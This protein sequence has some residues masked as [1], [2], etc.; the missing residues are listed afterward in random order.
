MANQQIARDPNTPVPQGLDEDEQQAA[1]LKAAK[2]RGGV[3]RG[4]QL[5]VVPLGTPPLPS[6]WRAA[7]KV[8]APGSGK[9]YTVYMIIPPKRGPGPTGTPTNQPVSDAGTMPVT[10]NQPNTQT[11]IIPAESPQAP[12]NQLAETW[13]G[14]GDSDALVEYTEE[15]QKV[16][17]NPNATEDQI[18]EKVKAGLAEARRVSLLGGGDRDNSM[19]SALMQQ[20]GKAV[21]QVAKMKSDALE[22]VIQQEEKIPNSVTDTKFQD[23]IKAALAAERQRQLMGAANDGP[24]EALALTG[25]AITIVADRKADAV[26]DLLTRDKQSPGSVTDSQFS[27]AIKDLLGIVREVQLLG[28]SSRKT[29]S[30]LANV[31]EVMKVVI[32]RKA[33]SLR[34]LIHQK[35]SGGGVTD[36]QIQQAT[37]DLNQ[38][39]EQGR[40]MGISVP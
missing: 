38:L 29:D 1:M 3:H 9:A 32:Q 40:R 6:P 27:G 21:N 14:A 5:T 13:L 11:G 16:L 37:D 4:E 24:S 12:K 20:V 2:Q 33:E 30:A 25:K 17:D 31:G 35:A 23:R 34:K 7:G 26:Q 15:L 8:A 10:Q 19:V 28:A 36:D 39:R 22:D 18:S